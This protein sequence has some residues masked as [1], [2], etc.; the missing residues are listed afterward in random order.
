MKKVICWLFGHKWFVIKKYSPSVRKVG[1]RRCKNVWGMND[2]V[3]SLIPWDREL[4]ELHEGKVVA[5]S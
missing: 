3:K 4:E 2:H 1:C 5:E